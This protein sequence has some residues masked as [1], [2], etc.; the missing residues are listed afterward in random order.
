MKLIKRIFKTHKNNI[1]IEFFIRYT[2]QE[3]LRYFNRE[4][5]VRITINNGVI[6]NIKDEEVYHHMVIDNV[7]DYEITKIMIDDTLASWN[8][9]KDIEV[10]N[11]D[12]Q[13]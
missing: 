6:I 1:D 3:F 2:Q 7:I 12:N 8:L 10:T 5:G 4:V 9:N 11:N 13:A